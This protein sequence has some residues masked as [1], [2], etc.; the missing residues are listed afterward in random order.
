LKILPITQTYTNMFV[1]L[2]N[3][4]LFFYNL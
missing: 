1:I 3:T 4:F 2:L